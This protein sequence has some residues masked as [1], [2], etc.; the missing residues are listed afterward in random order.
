MAGRQ[1]QQI[2]PWNS[3]EVSRIESAISSAEDDLRQ[4]DALNAQA[5]LLEKKLAK[6]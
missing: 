2:T 1:D 3:A 5:S 6:Q 4:L